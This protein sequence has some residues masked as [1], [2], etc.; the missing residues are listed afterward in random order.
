MF[1][2][3]VALPRLVLVAEC[4][5]SR[6]HKVTNYNNLSHPST[7]QI[8]LGT[9]VLQRYNRIFTKQNLVEKDKTCEE[10]RFSV[11]PHSQLFYHSNHCLKGYG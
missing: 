9:Y 11:R 6:K 10:G 5:N 3:V 2:G 1:A 7:I 4:H 8:T